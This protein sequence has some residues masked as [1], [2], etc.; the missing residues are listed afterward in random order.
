MTDLAVLALGFGVI[1]LAAIILYSVAGLVTRHRQAM[2]GVLAGVLAFLG[3]SHAMTTVLLNH[4]PFEYDVL[5]TVVPMLGLGLGAIAAWAVLEG[6]FIRTEPN[7]VLCAAVV[8]VSLHSFGD[9]LVLGA[10]FT[11]PFFPILRVDPLTVSATVVH[12]FIEGSLIVVPALAASWRPR[13]TF[14]LLFVS[15]ASI[16]AAYLPSWIFDVYGVA[17][18]ALEIPTFLAAMEAGFALLLL[19]RAFVPLASTERGARWL[20]WTAVGFLGITL[21][22]M[23]VE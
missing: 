11:G 9:G 5:S 17:P 2:W 20:A 6:P 16:P 1:P 14:P 21:V 7:R 10:P 3:L 4:I 22:H 13:L 12:R 23:F 18:G 19:L 15:L 8:F